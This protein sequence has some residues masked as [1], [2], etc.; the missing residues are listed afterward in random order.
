M[1]EMFVTSIGGKMYAMPING[2]KNIT[3]DISDIYCDFV[4]QIKPLY[5]ILYPNH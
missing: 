2:R 5:N 1:N 3:D 4:R